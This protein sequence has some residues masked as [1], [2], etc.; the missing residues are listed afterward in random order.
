MRTNRRASRRYVPW[1]PIELWRLIFQLA[2]SSPTSYGGGYVPFQPLRDMAESTE[3]LEHERLR[4]RTC[5]A[6]VRVSR[7]WRLVAAEFLYK[8][9]RI[10]N[11]HAL[12][13]LMVGLHRSREDNLGGFG[14]YI[15]RLELPMRPT[16]FAS[17][18]SHF[19]LFLRPRVP[20]RVSAGSLHDVLRFCSNLE[21]L[22]RPYLGLDGDEI[23][24]WASLIEA[25]LASPTPLL[26][27]L[28]RL[29]WYVPSLF[30]FYS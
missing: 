2:T 17:Q 20:P 23:R 26:P 9:V 21:I 18:P 12:H 10:L 16:N 1:L 6:L 7:L 27:H 14:R 5:A 11:A 28:R 25:P 29:E 24:F 3:Y 13:S 22:V 8:D 19:S 4:L 30:G 15:R